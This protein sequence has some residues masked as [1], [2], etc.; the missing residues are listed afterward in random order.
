MEGVHWRC[1]TSHL[2][3]VGEVPC[4]CAR[5]HFTPSN[6][7]LGSEVSA[8]S[9]AEIFLPILAGGL[10]PLCSDQTRLSQSHERVEA[11]INR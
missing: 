4:V 2:A 7:G 9:P 8:H 5:E 1:H 11:L 10:S 3:L 6:L